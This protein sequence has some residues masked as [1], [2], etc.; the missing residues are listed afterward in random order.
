L[1]EKKKN[2]L[3]QL[4]PKSTFIRGVT[5]IVGST[6][7]SQILLI[8]AA[9][10]L[11]RL[12]TPDDFGMLAVYGSLLAVIVVVASLHYELAIPLADEEN[13]AANI[14]VL[15]LA[16]V[17]A[18]S[19][20]TGVVS[21]LFGRIITEVLGVPRL[22]NY[23]W[24]LP[25]GVLLTGF[26][27]VFNYYGI[28]AKRFGDIATTRLNQSLATLAIQIVGFKL[29]GISLLLGQVIGQAVGTIKLAIQTLKNPEFSHLSLS[30]IKT[31]LVRYK[32]F[33]MYATGSSLV[34][35]AGHQL[36]TLI[37]AMFFSAGAAGLYALANR[38][39]T[40]PA[41][42]IGGALA[43][44]F[45]SHGVDRHREGTLGAMY[46]QLQ[47]T[48]VQ[49]GLP[50]TLF[51][52]L[53]GPELFIV[54]FGEIWRDAGVFSQWL[55]IG[56]FLGFV[57]SPLS[58]IYTILEKQKI[59]MVLQFSLFLLRLIGILFGVWLDSILW[60]VISFSVGGALGY[61]VYIYYGARI[62]GCTLKKMSIEMICG[63]FKSIL[64]MTPLIMGLILN[65]RWIIALLGFVSLLMYVLQLRT[66]SRSQF[67]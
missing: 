24:L 45:L 39:L 15:C 20:I 17:V 30:K 7:V 31:N 3:R 47:N 10:I 41:N 37:F 61:M 66:L 32:E 16:L 63:I 33:P 44:V 65:V 60:A 5:V 21:Y 34:N 56:T 27:T 51:I 58:Q 38:L 50:P 2:K 54:L 55:A 29:G 40:I 57:V 22:V 11:T 6:A 49:I 23:L 9:P 18:I 8:L 62:S 36:P 64:I 48:L 1:I 67:N 4:L 42:L 14:V 53:V 43:Q 25:F 26:Y 46:A 19:L 52:V 28:R 59:G 35:T 13:D 12:Y